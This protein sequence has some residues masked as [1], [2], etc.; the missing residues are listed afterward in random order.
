[1]RLSWILGGL[2]GNIFLDGIP[3]AVYLGYVPGGVVGLV[4]LDT[5]LDGKGNA[6]LSLAMYCTVLNLI[7]FLIF[8]IYFRCLGDTS[9]IIHAVEALLTRY[10]VEP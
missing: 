5:L 2:L 9:L 7:R 8:V 6:G 10:T 1:M 3:R 4:H